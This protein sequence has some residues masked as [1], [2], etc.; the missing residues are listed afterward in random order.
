MVPKRAP[1]RLQAERVVPL[2][3][4]LAWAVQP[5]PLPPGQ[6]ALVA[7]LRS[8][9]AMAER[10]PGLAAPEM[11]AQVARLRSVQAMALLPWAERREWAE[12]LP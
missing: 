3:W 5:L 12:R 8:V 11:A 6:V 4:R 9:Q 1:G 10:L 7:R 2:R